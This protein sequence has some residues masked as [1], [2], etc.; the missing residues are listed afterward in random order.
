MKIK[1]IDKIIKLLKKE[2]KNWRYPFV[3]E[4]SSVV[5][6]PFT[7][8]ISCLLSLRTKDEVTAK[9]SIRLLKKYNTPDKILKLSH[10]QIEK[11]IYPVGFYRTKA[12]RIKEISKTLIEKYNGKV[13]DTFEELIKLKGV[14]PKTAS[15]VVVYGYNK[16][17]HI[18]TDTH[19]NQIANR[20]GWVKTKLPEKTQMELEKIIP[21]KYWCDLNELF[22]QFGQ[23]ICV[24]VSP[25]CSK[26]PISR[27]C[28]RIGVKKSR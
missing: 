19:V 28:P 8:L 16:P 20:L 22:V 23:N 6:D 21:K 27:Y 18:P 13:P 4:W 7:T 25:F 12:K 26:C 24:P 11:L 14:G 17:I 15:I 9:A 2:S 10:K 5:K 3:S 1:N